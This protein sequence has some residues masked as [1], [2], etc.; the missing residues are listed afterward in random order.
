MIT[1]PNKLGPR[2]WTVSQSDINRYAQF[3]GANDPLH[4]DP[5]FAS[6]TEFGKTIAQ[7]LLLH[8]R[9]FQL[10]EDAATVSDPNLAVCLD[11]RFR[12]A[13]SPGDSIEYWADLVPSKSADG[14]TFE[15]HCR[16][17]DGTI[18][19]EGTLTVGRTEGGSR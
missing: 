8:G 2:Y 14:G 6:T 13:L 7:G 3:S 18:V 16:R 15:I 19:S 9:I 5:T 1:L 12:A 10:I 17:H 11:I 4:V